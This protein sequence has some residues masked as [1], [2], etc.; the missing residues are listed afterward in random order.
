MLEM[1]EAEKKALR[2]CKSNVGK[3]LEP[4]Y[5]LAQYVER[6]MAAELDDLAAMACM[7][8]HNVVQAVV[9]DVHCP[10]HGDIED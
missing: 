5:V 7:C 1:T 9:P 10:V 2:F 4:C 6:C 8:R 3:Q